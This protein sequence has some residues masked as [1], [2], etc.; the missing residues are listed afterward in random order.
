MNISKI[1]LRA[2]FYKKTWTFFDLHDKTVI[3][4]KEYSLRKNFSSLILY[5]SPHSTWTHM[6]SQIYLLRHWMESNLYENQQ[7]LKKH[8]WFIPAKSKNHF[9]KHSKRKLKQHLESLVKPLRRFVY[10]SWGHLKAD[11]QHQ[12]EKLFSSSLRNYKIP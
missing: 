12:S 3:N 10:N 4:H 2:F 9:I 6:F 8:S 7:Q 1:F 11:F 5:R